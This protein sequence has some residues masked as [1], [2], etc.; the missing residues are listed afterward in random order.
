MLDVHDRHPSRAAVLTGTVLT[1]RT[2]GHHHD[3]LQNCA[4][5]QAGLLKSSL[6][7]AAA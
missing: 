4:V 3:R 1:H 7:Q 5:K 2:S 6:V